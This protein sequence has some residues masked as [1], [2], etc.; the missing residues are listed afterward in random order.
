MPEPTF[1]ETTPK[2]R[3]A[4]AVTY[5]AEER[6]V[7]RPTQTVAGQ[8]TGLLE[9]E[10]PYMTAAR[11][12]GKQYAQ[13]RGLL[14]TTMG[15]EATEKAAIEAAF[16]IASQDAATF[17]EQQKINQAAINR[18][19]SEGAVAGQQTE[20]FNVGFGQ[21][22]YFREQ[23]V[24]NRMKVDAAGHAAALKQIGLQNLGAMNIQDLR[25]SAALEQLGLK[26]AGDVELQTII[27]TA[28]GKRQTAA[29]AAA[30]ERAAA[31]EVAAGERATAADIAAG[32][33]QTAADIATGERLAE[34]IAAEDR[35]AFSAY[36]KDTS[37]QHIV[38]RT[39]IATDP[40]MSVA[41]KNRA[42]TDLDNSYQGNMQAMAD[43]HGVDISFSEAPGSEG[44]PTGG[45][46]N[47][48]P[49]IPEEGGTTGIPGSWGEW[50]PGQPFPAIGPF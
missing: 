12:R 15:G 31:G 42:L 33:R 32:E 17:A 7:D 39:R 10:S 2:P 41:D 13:T 26:Q 25:N 28:A 27:D 19:R 37:Q 23:D 38:Q 48:E 18:A 44:V 36:V 21:E 49:F 5:E 1:Y 43:L 11:T 50:Q 16:P 20:L 6:K 9:A 3:E 8:I 34:N 40:E 45:P 4:A 22:S 47:V 35:G 30:G 14:N 24:Y 46:G 29:D